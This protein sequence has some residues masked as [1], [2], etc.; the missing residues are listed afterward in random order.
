MMESS[1][2]IPIHRAQS[3]IQM[4]SGSLSLTHSE[5]P[6][7]NSGTYFSLIFAKRRWKENVVSEYFCF[8]GSGEELRNMKTKR[9][10]LWND[11]D[12]VL[13]VESKKTMIQ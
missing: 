9:P 3:K 13:R 10:N 6:D 8:S 2:N 7:Y 11:H 4:V 5:S 12:S 1:P